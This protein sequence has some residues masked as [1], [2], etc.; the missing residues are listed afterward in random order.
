[1]KLFRDMNIVHAIFIIVILVLEKRSNLP[2]EKDLQLGSI[3][4]EHFQ[5]HNH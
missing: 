5:Q 4:T 2:A 1:M 3:G